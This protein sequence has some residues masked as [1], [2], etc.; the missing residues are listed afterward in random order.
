MKKEYSFADR[1][2]RTVDSILSD[3]ALFAELETILDEQK[4]VMIV[5]G[6]ISEAEAES[7][8]CQPEN[9]RRTALYFANKNYQKTILKR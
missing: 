2:N 6:G 9:L 4:A 5:D 7:Y 8:I 3:D 1:Y